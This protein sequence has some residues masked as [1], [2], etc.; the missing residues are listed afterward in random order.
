[1]RRGDGRKKKER[2]NHVRQHTLERRPG[3]ILDEGLSI[4]LS[5]L[6]PRLTQE[7]SRRSELLHTRWSLQL[8]FNLFA[9]IYPQKFGTNARDGVVFFSK[10]KKAL[11]HTHTRGSAMFWTK[12]PWRWPSWSLDAATRALA[13]TTCPHFRYMFFCRHNL[14]CIWQMKGERAKS[15]LQAGPD[16]LMFYTLMMTSR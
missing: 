8:I 9:I 2:R 12:S 7:E 6:W 15:F 1:M 10:L 14:K 16:A 5:S 4:C 3:T 11:W 13:I